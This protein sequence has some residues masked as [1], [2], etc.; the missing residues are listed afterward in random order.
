MNFTNQFHFYTKLFACAFKMYW[1]YKFDGIN[2]LCFVF[3][4][5]RILCNFQSSLLLNIQI[6]LCFVSALSTGMITYLIILFS[7]CLGYAALF[8]C[9]FPLAFHI[10]ILSF[11]L[12]KLELRAVSLLYLFFSKLT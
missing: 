3:L 12:L 5:F 1:I 7:Q 10:N 8:Y 2:I 4:N 9:G 6:M 11:L